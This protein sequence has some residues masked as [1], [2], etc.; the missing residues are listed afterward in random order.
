MPRNERMRGSCLGAITQLV[1]VTS[2]TKLFSTR[3]GP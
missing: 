2:L 1:Y 3:L